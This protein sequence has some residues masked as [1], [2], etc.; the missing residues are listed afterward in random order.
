[1]VRLREWIQSSIKLDCHIVFTTFSTVNRLQRKIKAVLGLD[2]QSQS[3]RF[4]T[5]STETKLF[6]MH[7]IL[8]LGWR[9]LTLVINSCSSVTEFPFFPLYLISFILSKWLFG[10]PLPVEPICSVIYNSLRYD[11]SAGIVTFHIREKDWNNI[12]SSLLDVDF[13]SRLDSGH[14]T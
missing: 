13:F 9:L 10:F 1:M 5:K 11:D 7:S 14:T 12:K 3:P 8:F 2:F 6:Y 4:L